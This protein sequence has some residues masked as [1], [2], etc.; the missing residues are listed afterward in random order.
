MYICLSDARANLRI[1]T[2]ETILRIE[3]T[4]ALQEYQI[5]HSSL[6]TLLG[7]SESTNDE[8]DCATEIHERCGKRNSEC[9]SLHMRITQTKQSH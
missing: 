8:A 9:F 1:P 4:F 2:K 3:Q 7:A 5:V 6:S